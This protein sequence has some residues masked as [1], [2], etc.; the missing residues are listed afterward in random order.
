[1]LAMPVEA[2][3]EA[4]DWRLLALGAMGRYFGS[5]VR[6]RNAEPIWQKEYRGD[7]SEKICVGR[8]LLLQCAVVENGEF[9]RREVPV[10]P[11]FGFDDTVMA[12]LEAQADTNWFRQ[13]TRFLDQGR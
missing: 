10:T 6:L 1:M 8:K 4:S 12:Y 3:P 7:A 5:E 2:E 13:P 11:D 9:I